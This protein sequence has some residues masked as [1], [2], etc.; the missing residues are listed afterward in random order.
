[1]SVR[2]TAKAHAA[3]GGDHTAGAFLLV[4][5]RDAYATY[6]LPASGALT[7]GR[8]ESNSVR[9]DD[10]LASRTH[11]CL[12]VGDAMYLEDVGSVNGT[13]V[14]DKVV[15]PGE[16]VRIAIGETIQIGSSVLIVQRRAAQADL[17][18]PETLRDEG[19]IPITLAPPSAPRAGEAMR[20]VLELA[21]RAA[22]GTI[23][24]L[25]TGETGV[26][27]ELLAETVHRASPRRSGPY[28]CLNCAALSETL[29]ESELFGHER[30]AFT[31]AVQAKP[32]LLETAASGTLFL[33]EVGELPLS[34]Q[35]KLLRVLETREV[36]RLGS[37]RPRRIDVRFIAATNRDLEAE[38]ARG[39]FRADLYYRL[40]GI[41]LTI[42]PLRSRLEEIR[43]LAETFL[44][45]ICRDL[46]RQPPLLPPASVRHLEAYGWPGNI[47]E[48]KNVIERAVLLCEGPILDAQYMPLERPLTESQKLTTSAAS[49]LAQ[50]EKDR[51]IEALAACAGNQSRAA[52]MLGIPRRTFVS[53]LDAYKIPRP[54][55]GL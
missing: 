11:A 55:K 42:P 28:V 25:I 51:I 38:V 6:D 12:H 21:E 40:N 54:K 46:G 45:Q 31:G 34:T 4:V 24:V 37:V 32:G 14:K 22:A 2:E 9:V 15:K 13:R 48:L 19:L 39:A 20:R 5:G 17:L 43:P 10:P 50:T 35:A 36:A 49:S 27:K 26:G 16:R 8:G 30:G 23:N 3:D 52:K 7:I 29:L 18:R 44:R 53:K 33:D 1:M 47:R 41:T